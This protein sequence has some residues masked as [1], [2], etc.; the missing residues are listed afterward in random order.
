MT[1]HLGH[2]IEGAP[3]FHSVAPTVTQLWG[4]EQWPWQLDAASGTCTYLQN[5]GPENLHPAL[6]H[7]C[8][9]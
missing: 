7:Y 4:A 6:C 3:N 9:E 1:A 2:S 8:Y 5:G